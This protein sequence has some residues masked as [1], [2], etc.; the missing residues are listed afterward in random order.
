MPKASAAVLL[1]D[2]DAAVWGNIGDRRIYQLRDNLLYEITPDNSEAYALYEAGKIRYPKIR[3]NALRHRLTKQLGG[4]CGPDENFS[5]PQK[6]RPGD[7]MLICTDGFW[8]SIHERQIE[9]T[10]KKSTSAQNWLDNMLKIVEKN[11]KHQKY[12]RFRDSFCAITI[13]L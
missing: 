9:K 11:I 13:K 4:E 2:G 10:L 12:S 7:S 5:Q 1:T 6:L 3:K 8:G